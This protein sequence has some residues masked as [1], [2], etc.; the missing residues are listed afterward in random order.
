MYPSKPGVV[1][2][3][4]ICHP[5]SQNSN[6]AEAMWA[7][8]VSAIMPPARVVVTGEMPDD[9]TQAIVIAN[10]Q[11]RDGINADGFFFA[12]HCWC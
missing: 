1:L 6:F 4:V 7:D 5:S 12:V 3:S 2:C 9:E 11:V 8:A 10:H